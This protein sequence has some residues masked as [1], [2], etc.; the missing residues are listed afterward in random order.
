MKNKKT[1]QIKEDKVPLLLK[2]II[3]VFLIL[4]LLY[5][6]FTGGNNQSWYPGKPYNER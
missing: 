1:E 5:L 4:C 3:I 6:V 2:V